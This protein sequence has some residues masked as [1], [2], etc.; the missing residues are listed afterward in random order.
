MYS[1]CHLSVILCIKLNH[2]SS[3]YSNEDL[4]QFTFHALQNHENSR[5]FFAKDEIKVEKNEYESIEDPENL[6]TYRKIAL[7]I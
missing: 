1:V 3:P 7:N 4:T 5:D 2:F 6:D